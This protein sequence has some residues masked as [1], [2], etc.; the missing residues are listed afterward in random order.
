MDVTPVNWP[1]AFGINAAVTEWRPIVTRD[2]RYRQLPKCERPFDGQE[3]GLP[4]TTLDFFR[5][6]KSPHPTPWLVSLPFS[7]LIY[8]FGTGCVCLKS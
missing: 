4:S 2:E 7:W 6:L 5:Q 8:W 3:A 1:A